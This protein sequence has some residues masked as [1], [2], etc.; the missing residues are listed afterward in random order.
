MTI[1][2]A[3]AVAARKE[4]ISAAVVAPSAVMLSPKTMVCAFIAA[5]VL[6]LIANGVSKYERFAVAFPGTLNAIAEP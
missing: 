1:G 4:S 5:M 6:C 3:G 2:D